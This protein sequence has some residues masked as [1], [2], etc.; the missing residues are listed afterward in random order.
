MCCVCVKSIVK[1]LRC[2]AHKC[3]RT[4]VYVTGHNA[5]TIDL[6]HNTCVRSVVNTLCRV[7]HTGFASHCNGSCHIAMGRVTLQWVMLHFNFVECITSAR[8]RVTWEEEEESCHISKGHI[9]FQR[10][11]SHANVSFYIRHNRV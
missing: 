6:T 9:T 11:I 2:V 5:F 7:T 4:S 10:V 3:D 8:C 1:A